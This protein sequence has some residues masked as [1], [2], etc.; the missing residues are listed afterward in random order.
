MAKVSRDQLKAWFMKG[1]YPIQEQ[2]HHW[3]DSYWH[4]DDKIPMSS[5]EGLT[6]TLNGKADASLLTDKQDRADNGL[7]TEAKTVVG[8]INEVKD[9]VDALKDAEGIA[10]TAPSRPAVNTV[11][12]A[13]DDL[14]AALDGGDSFEEITAGEVNSLFDSTE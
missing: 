11:A 1:L 2:F 8:A 6:D 9:T 3:I 13:L 4:K 7:D 12:E 5:V 10:Y 14:Y